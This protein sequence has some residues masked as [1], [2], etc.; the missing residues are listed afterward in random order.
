[1]IIDFHTHI[2]PPFMAQDRTNFFSADPAFALLY[3]S[4]KSRL[5]VA[6]D[7]LRSMDE[8]GIQRSV[9]FGFPWKDGNLF[10][11]HNDYILESVGRFPDRFIGFCC[12][13]PLAKEAAREVERCLDGGMSGIGEL[14]FYD[15]DLSPT[16]ITALVDI[17]ALSRRYDVPLL[18][19]TNEPLGH[20]YAGKTPMTLGQIYSLVQQYP[21]NRIVLAHWGG[22]ILFYG[23]MKKEVREV[24]KNVWFDTAASPYLYAPKIYKIAGDIVGVEKILF[25]SDYPLIS[26]ARYF[27]EMVEADLPEKSIGMIKGS[28]ASR[29]LHPSIH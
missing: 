3:G 11:R 8:S 23:L 26:P 1:M 4:P 22:G 21:F 14:A 10:R 28:N 19:H 20:D 29:L 24:L 27:Q 15:Q 5:V 12:F 2:F 7:L 16:L 25:G 17:M 9:V 6:E 18:I 13:H